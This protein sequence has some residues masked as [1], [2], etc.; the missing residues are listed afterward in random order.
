MFLRICVIAAGVIIHTD[1][2]DKTGTDDCNPSVKINKITIWTWYAPFAV[3]LRHWCRDP[4]AAISELTFSNVFL[5]Q[6]S[7][8]SI[9]VSMKLVPKGLNNNIQHWFRW[10]LGAGH[11]T[12]HYLNQWWSVYRRIYASLGFYVLKYWTIFPCLLNMYINFYITPINQVCLD[13]ISIKFSRFRYKIP[14]IGIS[15]K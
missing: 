1:V 14:D 12:S 15:R 13:T 9:K 11:A 2:S 8:N 6:N 10:W 5:K 4:L 7:R 3:N